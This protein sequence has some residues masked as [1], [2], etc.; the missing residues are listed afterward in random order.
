MGRGE[1]REKETRDKRRTMEN[2]AS[3]DSEEFVYGSNPVARTLTSPVPGSPG[4]EF[5]MNVPR[6]PQQKSRAS[7]PSKKHEQLGTLKT[8]EGSWKL[9]SE[10]TL[11]SPTKV[12]VAHGSKLP[13]I[14]WPNL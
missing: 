2:N 5:Q 9:K 12:R 14:A 13:Q 10:R 4:R 6:H 11:N 1:G 7:V 3:R 8:R